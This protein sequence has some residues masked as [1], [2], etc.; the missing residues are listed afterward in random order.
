MSALSRSIKNSKLSDKI[1]FIIDK[2][3]II[4]FSK[5]F[6]TVIYCCT[7]SYIWNSSMQHRYLWVTDLSFLWA[8]IFLGCGLFV[9][10][11][12]KK[13]L[14]KY[15]KR[16][17]ITIIFIYILLVLYSSVTL[18]FDRTILLIGYLFFL[19]SFLVLPLYCV[20]RGAF[21]NTRKF[22][23]LNK[24]LSF[25]LFIVSLLLYLLSGTNDPLLSS[26][27]LC[28]A[29]VYIVAFFLSTIK[30]IL[31]LY[32]CIFFIYLFFLSTTIYPYL[33]IGSVILFFVSKFYFFIKHD[34][35]YPTFLEV[36]D[37]S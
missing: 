27:L 17:L 26:V 8:G 4:D 18:T 7:L 14:L 3:L 15:N 37:I 31:L 36:Y 25:S 32:R 29:P 19:S 13:N 10:I 21:K 30:G 24:I 9:F 35:K 22:D 2:F 16:S 20:A 33:F 12:D 1:V 11:L 6:F 34:I 28:S 5:L 23:M